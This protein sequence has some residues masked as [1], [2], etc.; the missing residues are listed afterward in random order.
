MYTS[1][2]SCVSSAAR[3]SCLTFK[4]QSH[5]QAHQS[6]LLPQK[7]KEIFLRPCAYLPRITIAGKRAE[8]STG[9]ECKPNRWNFSSGRV[10]G[11]KETIISF[12]TYLYTLQAKVFEAH[13]LLLESGEN[14]TAESVKAKF[15]GKEEVVRQIP[16]DTLDAP[17]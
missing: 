16:S 9:R 3:L 1:C 4:P 7:A 12:N 6:P 11:T 15:I 13:R 5:E 10:S 2:T 8:I 14:I 17:P